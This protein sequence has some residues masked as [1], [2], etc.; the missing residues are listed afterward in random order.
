VS[1]P[2][3]GLRFVGVV[4]EEQVPGEPVVE[5]ERLCAQADLGFSADREDGAGHAPG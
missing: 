5:A 1:L 4:R 3:R 2:R